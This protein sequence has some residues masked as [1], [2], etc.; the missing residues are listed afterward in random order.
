[1]RDQDFTPV[2]PGGQYV[3]SRT[4]VRSMIAFAYNVSFPSIQ[5]LGLPNWAKNQV[6]AVA[7]KPAEGFPVLP[8]GENQ[9]QVRLMMRTMLADRFH[10]QVHAETRRGPVFHLELAKG[11]I[12]IKEVNPP[13]PPAK[14]SPVQAA[15]S[16]SEGRMIGN[17]ST[18]AGF[19]TALTIMLDRPVADQ[20]GLK[21]YY[22]FDVHWRDPA[23]SGGQSPSPFLGADGMGLL[24]SNLQNQ[25][26]LRLVK[27]DGPVEYCVVDHVEPPTGN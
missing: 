22:D 3:Y 23:A 26:G 6:Y 15:W 5:L 16:D 21:G 24:I 7:A 27:T 17:K 20:T 12:K 4:T 25:F 18:M 9:E 10:L 19:A 1:M 11:G 13:V 14:E 2:L 8:S